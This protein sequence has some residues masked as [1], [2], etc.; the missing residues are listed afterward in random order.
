MAKQTKQER[1]KAKR[2]MMNGLK[3]DSKNGY[4]TYKKQ[5]G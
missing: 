4:R 1:K 3:R 2:K 5:G